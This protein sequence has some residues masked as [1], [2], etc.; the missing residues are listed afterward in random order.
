MIPTEK[1]AMNMS[2]IPLVW[3]PGPTLTIAA[4]KAVRLR[5]EIMRM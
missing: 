4:E 2:A 3:S 5:Q 1:H